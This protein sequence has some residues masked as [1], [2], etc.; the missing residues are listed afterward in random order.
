MTIADELRTR[1]FSMFIF[2]R[3]IGIES[4]L[5]ACQVSTDNGELCDEPRGG[6]PSSTVTTNDAILLVD[7]DLLLRDTKWEPQS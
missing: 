6:A 2:A 7:H 1:N 4:V 5:T 3:T